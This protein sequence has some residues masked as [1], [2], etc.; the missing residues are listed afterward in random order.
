MCDT[1]DTSAVRIVGDG[2]SS[3][4]SNPHNKRR[5]RKIIGDS[6]H[7]ENARQKPLS[8]QKPPQL[9]AIPLGPVD[10]FGQ[11][12]SS[13]SAP[14]RPAFKSAKSKKI[15]Q[16]EQKRLAAEESARQ[17]QGEAQKRWQQIHQAIL[18]TANPILRWEPSAQLVQSFIGYIGLVSSS[19]KLVILCES[20]ANAQ[21]VHAR[22]PVSCESSTRRRRAPA[23]RVARE[24]PRGYRRGSDRDC[25]PC[26]PPASGSPAGPG[27]RTRR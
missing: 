5:T 21:H 23:R 1:N 2:P 19:D 15:E 12:A 11:S 6:K 16:Q 4:S 18:D 8:F 3:S 13:S 25:T 24:A 10:S 17:K 20:D 26:R 9:V 27:G 7:T 22:T 14:S